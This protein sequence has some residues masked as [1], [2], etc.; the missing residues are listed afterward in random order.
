MKWIL[1]IVAV[2]ASFGA[3]P[4]FFHYKTVNVTLKTPPFVDH[5]LRFFVPQGAPFNAN[6]MVHAQGAGSGTFT[7][8]Q[9]KFNTCSGSTC[10][11]TITNPTAGHFGIIAAAF[12]ANQTITS[13]TGCSTSWTV[14]A[15]TSAG[16]ATAGWVSMAYCASLTAVG[17]TLTVTAGA[18]QQ[19][20]EFWEFSSST[21]AS[22]DVS[23]S[24]LVTVNCT[25]CVGTALTLTG[26]NDFIA[27]IGSCGGACSAPSGTPAY[28]NDNSNPGGD[29]Q[30]HLLNSTNGGAPTVN[31]SPTS[32][33][34]TASIAI[35]D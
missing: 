6:G 21:S 11:I 9:A 30:A 18:N 23:G 14:Q 28:T 25:A 32:H 22:F 3:T 19:L 8:T 35:K 5:N 29:F 16:D 15:N 7:F 26:G 2:T 20:A 27:T 4:D 12:G 1:G 24:N 17:T 13:A 31:Q 33:I 10:A 34:V